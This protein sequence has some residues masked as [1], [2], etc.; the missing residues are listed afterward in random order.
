VTATLAAVPASTDV[1]VITDT[2]Q[3][4]V[5]PSTCLAAHLTDALSCSLP[6]D[7][8]LDASWR[9]AETDAALAGGAHV[10]DLNDLLCDDESCGLIMGDRLMYRDPHH[11]TASFAST[12]APELAA[13]LDWVTPA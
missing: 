2:P 4:A 11:L 12:L 10:V 13:E 8:A 7:I 5:T 6:R 3:F 9:S 1:T